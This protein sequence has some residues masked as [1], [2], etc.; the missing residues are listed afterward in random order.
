[1]IKYVLLIAVSFVVF[2]CGKKVIKEVPGYDAVEP[3]KEQVKVAEKEPE[4]KPSQVVVPTVRPVT[5][6]V[7]F[8]FD[9]D[10]PLNS[11]EILIFAGKRGRFCITGKTCPIGTDEYNYDLGMRRALSVEKYLRD[12]GITNI[13][14]ESTGENDL[15]TKDEKN[16]WMNRVAIVSVK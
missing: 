12:L 7:Y 4:K 9:S 1:M 3:K 8:G 14:V 6:Y 11:S 15:V 16:Y 13:T 5:K 10:V 2:S